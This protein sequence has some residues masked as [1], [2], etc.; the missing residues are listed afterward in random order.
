[1]SVSN[2]CPVRCFCGNEIQSA[3]SS[4][5]KTLRAGGTIADALNN[6][7]LPMSSPFAPPAGAPNSYVSPPSI[8]CRA[9]LM[10]NSDLSTQHNIYQ[11]IVRWAEG[12]AAIG[13]NPKSNTIKMSSQIQQNPANPPSINTKLS[14][15][16]ST[17]Q[18]NHS[19]RVSFAPAPDVQQL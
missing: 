12:E 8:C 16:K 10:C 9:V 15:N 1:M 5:C 19:R 18:S 2:L 17:N 7:G 13:A 14:T 6:S 3:Y 4:Y 11:S